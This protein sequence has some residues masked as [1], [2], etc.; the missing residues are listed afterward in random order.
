MSAVG[1]VRLGVG[2]KCS[3]LKN[4]ERKNT[5]K[6]LR[7]CTTTQSYSLTAV[8]VSRVAIIQAYPLLSPCHVKNCIFETADGVL[9]STIEGTARRGG[10]QLDVGNAAGQLPFGPQLRER[11]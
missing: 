3:E 5:T 10:R 7:T 8:I 11:S 1:S 4:K 6:Q 9:L 2:R